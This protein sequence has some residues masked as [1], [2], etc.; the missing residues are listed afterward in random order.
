MKPMIAGGD[1]RYFDDAEQARQRLVELGLCEE[2]FRGALEM[3][4]ADA[5]SCTSFDA[6]AMPGITFWSR[7]N[8]Y[9]AERL[10]PPPEGWLHT[11]RDS[12]LR[13][14]HPT[15][16]HAVTAISASGGVADCTKRV[17]SKN[18][19]GSIMAK[20][21][22]QTQMAMLSP[23]EVLYGCDLDEIPLWFLLYKRDEGGIIKA[24]LS[25]PLEMNGKFIDDWQERIPLDLPDL[26]DPGTDISLLDTPPDGPDGG[27]GAEVPVEYVGTE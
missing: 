14:F 2:I 27:N 4:A 13:V 24:E 11:S 6:P 5:R 10:Y 25:L 18:P 12:I 16:S 7:T 19:K 3:A 8:R 22:R 17:R 9:L 20:L 15:L 1:L 23:D 26:G 21:V